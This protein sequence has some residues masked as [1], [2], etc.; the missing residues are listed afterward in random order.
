MIKRIGREPDNK[1]LTMINIVKLR[2]CVG[3]L[4]PDAVEKAAKL[5]ELT[6]EWFQELLAEMQLRFPEHESVYQRMFNV[7]KLS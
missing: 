1:K 3:K 6:T 7:D 2:D 5:S 4:R